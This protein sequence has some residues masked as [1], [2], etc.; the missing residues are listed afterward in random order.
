MRMTVRFGRLAGIE[1]HTNWSVLLI[2][3][4]TSLRRGMPS[5]G[6]GAG[7]SGEP[8]WADWA[9]TLA[10]IVEFATREDVT[11]EDR[12]EARAAVADFDRRCR[13]WRDQQSDSSTSQRLPEAG[14]CPPLS[15]A[16]K[17]SPLVASFRSPVVAG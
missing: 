9:Q 4:R 1:I 5:F 15:V 10:A 16:M 7:V 6:V 14:D 2:R 11:D 12:A 13:N 8:D 17:K 3:R